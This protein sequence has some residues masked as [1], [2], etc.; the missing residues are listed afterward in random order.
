VNFKKIFLFANALGL[1]FTL[2]LYMVS[3]YRYSSALKGDHW[4]EIAS[5]AWLLLAIIVSGNPHTLS[6]WKTAGACFLLSTILVFLLLL[7][8]GLLLR[9]I[10]IFQK[11]SGSAA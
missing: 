3:A 5:D 4:V 11:G 2:M 10:K 7:I 9:K 8:W 6:L 1:V